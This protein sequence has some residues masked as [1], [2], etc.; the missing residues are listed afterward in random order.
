MSLN[1]DNPHQKHLR[2]QD[3]LLASKDDCAFF[4]EVLEGLSTAVVWVDANEKIRFMNVAAGEIFQTSTT[5]ILGR[6]WSFILPGL[7]DN[8]YLAQEKKLTIHEY[9]VELA[10]FNKVRVSC[11]IS[12]YEMNGQTGWLIEIFNTER[13][14]RIVEEDERWHQYEAGNLLVRTL[15]HEVKNP[16]AG[17]LGAT[18]LL[19]KR[20]QPG[21]KD[22]AFLEIISKEVLRLKNLVDRM[23]GPKLSATKD[24]HN[25]HELIRYV[26]QIIEGEKPANVYV[27]LDYDPSIPEI[28]MDFE[29]MVQAL[30]NLLKNA[31]QAMEAHGGLLTIKTRVEHK[32]TLGAF[33]YPLV[34]VLSIMD[35]GEGIPEEVFDSIFY[36][37]V[38]SKKKVQA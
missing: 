22:L 26:L 25:I 17:I 19:Q 36:P 9:T 20:H 21:D 23:L 7:L 28:M 5:R 24:Y 27:K 11:T 38:S 32:F 8:I 16:L 13:H 2:K 18:Q 29:A 33:T 4:K 35:E 37:M 14:H 10:D 15:A 12:P 6:N 1:K 34:A 30:L 3:L 31:I